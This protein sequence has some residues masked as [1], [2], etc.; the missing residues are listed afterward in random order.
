MH[1]VTLD[2]KEYILRCD[3]NVAEQIE[4][5]YGSLT[6]L[7]KQN[8]SAAA[9]KFLTAA[10][11]NEHYKYTGSPDRVTEDFVG[12]RLTMADRLPVMN[13]VLACLGESITPKNA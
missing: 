8:G 5:K 11:I 13:T 2:G 7:Q 12:A 6:G 9:L 1:T 4:E 3:L 10:M